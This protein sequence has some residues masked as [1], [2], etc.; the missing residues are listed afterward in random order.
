[1]IQIS[2][3][4]RT[5]GQG[6]QQV[7]ALKDISLAIERGQMIALK[8]RSGS[9]KTTLLNCVGGLDQPT[10]GAVEIDGTNVTQLDEKA[11]TRWR[12]ATVGFIF[13]AHGLLPTMS[14]FENVDMGL[15]IGKIP[16]R[17]R[18][19]RTLTSLEQVGLKELQHHRPYELS[20]GQAQRVAVA[21]ALALRPK[22]ILADE[23]TGELD[24]ETSHAI[25]QQ[26]R[27]LM[28]DYGT[29]ILLATH[30]D[31]VSEYADR[32]VHLVDGAIQ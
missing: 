16:F 9:G 5:Y 31:L 29:T 23:P 22:V 12:Q 4:Q 18:A 13:Q 21:R 30:D 14:A 15:R 24:S 11:R 17:E 27:Q 2:H 3:L 28:A 8:G 25:L 26:L 7:H 1:M 19:E 10:S 32:T 6:N 20:G